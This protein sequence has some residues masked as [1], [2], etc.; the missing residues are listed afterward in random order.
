MAPIQVVELDGV[1]NELEFESHGSSQ[2]SE[3]YKPLFHYYGYQRVGS[4]GEISYLVQLFLALL[5]Y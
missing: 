1:P 5:E 2:Q 3:K 4:S